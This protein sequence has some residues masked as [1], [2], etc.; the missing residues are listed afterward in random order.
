MLHGRVCTARLF[1]ERAFR[2]ALDIIDASKEFLLI[3]FKGKNKDIVISS[4]FLPLI[5]SQKVP[6]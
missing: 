4:L 6:F 5:V 3:V 2:G 1:V